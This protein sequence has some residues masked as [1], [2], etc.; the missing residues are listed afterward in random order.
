M[1][2]HSTNQDHAV[3]LQVTTY[4][5]I[6][7]LNKEAHQAAEG[8]LAYVSEKGGQLYIR[9]RNGWRKIQVCIVCACFVSLYKEPFSL[10]KADNYMKST[11]DHC[12]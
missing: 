12:F 5:T 2:R 4:K 10:I 7:A 11:W 9:T 1:W 8:T 6:Q 3:F